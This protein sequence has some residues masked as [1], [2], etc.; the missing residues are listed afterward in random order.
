MIKKL[1]NLLG[2][3]YVVNDEHELV[4]IYHITNY[5]V[6]QEN[7]VK[8]KNHMNDWTLYEVQ[9]GESF[10]ICEFGNYDIAICGLYILVKKIFERPKGNSKIKYELT[11]CTE[12][13]SDNISSI[14]VKEY[15][16]KFFN[17]NNFKKGAIVLEK[18]NGY[19]DINYCGLNDERINIVNGRTFSNAVSVFYNYIVI[20]HEFEKLINS[21]I[22]IMNIKLSVEEREAIKRVYL[23]K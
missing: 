18:V 17:L 15:D 2:K 21:L 9:R 11:Q 4:E 16:K 12:S 23:G 5:G 10:E 20:V 19:Y 1:A 7:Y 8:M 3:D 22:S 6:D 13:N 14:L